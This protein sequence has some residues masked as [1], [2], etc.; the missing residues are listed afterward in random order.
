MQSVRESFSLACR[1]L[2]AGNAKSRGARLR[3]SRSQRIS[4]PVPKSGRSSRMSRAC[5]ALVGRRSGSRTVDLRK[6]LIDDVFIAAF[7]S[8]ASAPL[9]DQARFDL[10]E[11]AMACEDNIIFMEPAPRRDGSTLIQQSRPDLR[12]DDTDSVRLTCHPRRRRRDGRCRTQ[13]V[14]CP[15]AS[16]PRACRQRIGECHVFLVGEPVG[17]HR[18]RPRAGTMRPSFP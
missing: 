6:D 18:R 3:V 14:S 8:Q 16:H 10:G 2:A 13:S 1:E 15:S 11:L 9:E 17:R 5:G 12:G 4:V 7:G